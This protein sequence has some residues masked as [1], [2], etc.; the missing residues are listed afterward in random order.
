MNAKTRPV[1]AIG[2]RTAKAAVL[3]AGV[4]LAACSPEHDWREVRA[5]EAGYRVM[6]PAKP[7]SMTRA[8]HLETMR[9]D[10][11]MQGAQAGGVSYTIGAVRLPDTSDA[12]RERA[13]AAMRSAMVRNIG[14]DERAA[15][16][17]AVALVDAAGHRVG[18]VQGVEVEAVGRMRDADAVLIAR[19]VGLDGRVWQ[20]V[21][22]GARPEREQAA[23]F[24]DSLALRR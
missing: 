5:D 2:W 6:L 22:L 17:V 20:A 14:G 23:Q 4:V 18:T 1:A 15:R 19:F 8:I 13:L 7:A 21:V 9:V 3:A 11:S 10:M 12:A 16:P 24:L